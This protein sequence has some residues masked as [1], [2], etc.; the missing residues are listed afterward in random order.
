MGFVEVQITDLSHISVRF[1]SET[2][3]IVLVQAGMQTNWFVSAIDCAGNIADF[4][5]NCAGKSSFFLKT[6]KRFVLKFLCLS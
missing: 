5:K 6:Q 1:V 3:T 2:H 4:T